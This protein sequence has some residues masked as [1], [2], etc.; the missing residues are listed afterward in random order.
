MRDPAFIISEAQFRF[1]K[2]KNDAG[3]ATTLKI[4]SWQH[5]GLFQDQANPD[6]AY[7]GDYGVYG[8]IDQQLWHLSGAGPDM[9]ISA[10]TRGIDQPVRPQSD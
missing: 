8:V 5:L 7:R 3:L 4:G 10:F 9:G 2:D 6:F 1:N